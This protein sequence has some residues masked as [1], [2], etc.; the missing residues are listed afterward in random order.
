MATLRYSRVVPTLNTRQERTRRRQ[1]EQA[2]LGGTWNIRNDH[3]SE[4]RTVRME[5]YSSAMWALLYSSDR[6][7]SGEIVEE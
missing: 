6:V 2:G 3:L 7:G 4:K 5:L 1:N